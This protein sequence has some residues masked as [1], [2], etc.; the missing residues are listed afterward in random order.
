MVEVQTC[1][2]TWAKN[3]EARDIEATVGMYDP[4]MGRLLGTVDEAESPRRDSIEKI[5]EYFNG[6]LGGNQAVKPSFPKFD[7]DDVFF[8]SDN[9]AVYSGYYKFALTKNDVTKDVYAKFSYIVRKTPEYGV[10]IVTHNSGITPSGAV[11]QGDADKITLSEVQTCMETWA[12]NAKARDIDATVGMYDPEMGRLLG[13]VDE[14]ESP[15]RDSIE[16]I[17]EYFNGFLGGNQ[18]V[19]PMFPKFDRTYHSR[20]AEWPNLPRRPA[21]DIHVFQ[22]VPA[23]NGTILVTWRQNNEV[24]TDV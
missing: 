2:E 24:V 18:A 4:E 19:E 3:A 12:K 11:V 14:A 9:T 15:R 21:A 10:K 22:K 5:R 23:V 8:L 6:F 13:T 16:K 7:K 1:M 20:L 17:R